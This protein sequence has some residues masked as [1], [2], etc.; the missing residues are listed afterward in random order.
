MDDPAAGFAAPVLLAELT[1][2]LPVDA[3]AEATPLR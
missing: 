2:V 1:R 3:A